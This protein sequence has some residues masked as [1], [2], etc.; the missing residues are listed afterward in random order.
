MFHVF[1]SPLAACLARDPLTSRPIASP[2]P[3]FFCRRLFSCPR[4]AAL[5][6]TSPRI[7]YALAFSQMAVF[8]TNLDDAK[9]MLREMVQSSS[10]A[11]EARILVVSMEK[12]YGMVK[13]GP[14]ST[15][16]VY[17]LALS[18]NSC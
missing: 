15:G 4:F 12:A 1:E 13:K 3:L 11:K 8:F 9:E 14:V 2:F 5:L 16:C 10:Y 7:P 6:K 18:P 17:W